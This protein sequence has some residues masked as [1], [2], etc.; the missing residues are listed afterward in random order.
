M[1]QIG[2]PVIN[3]DLF[4]PDV[5]DDP[6]TYFGYLRESDPVHWN[7]RY[8]VWIV[9]RHD[10][11]SYINMHPEI[12]SS[13]VPQR[14]KRPPYPPIDEA[15]LDAYNYVQRKQMQRIITA[16]PPHHREMR[17]AL[18]RFFT[19]AA[20]KRWRPLI[21]N[22]VAELVSEV[23]GNRMDVVRDFAIPFPLLVISELMD[24]PEKDRLYVRE[25]AE[26]LLIGPRTSSSRMREIADAMDAMDEYMSPVV[27]ERLHNPGEDVVSMLTRAEA[28]GALTHEEVMQNVAFMVVAGH[29]TTINLIC[30]AMLAFARHP[31]Q[32]ALLKSDPAGRASGATEEGLRFDPP[33]KSLER[34]AVTDV[35]LQDR[36]IHAGDRVRWVIASA[37]RDPRR[38][39]NPDTFDITRSPNPH[40]SFGHGIHTCMGAALTRLEG[41]V[42]FKAFAE[43][44]G[45]NLRL[46]TDSIEWAGALHLRSLKALTISW[47]S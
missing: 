43:R 33:V 8:Q 41:Q 6:Y 17:S 16:D 24:I 19:P 20:V 36:Q 38:F 15:D 13:S 32:W 30:N 42:T 18:H 39:N 31:D 34:I 21:E 40:L 3:E 46:E 44:M 2:E 4:A 28:S 47:S 9:T 27:E 14:D 7:E 23:K 22:A 5:N 37:N 35:E 11:A 29:E 10:D 12:F 45:A 25:V 26:N 1:T